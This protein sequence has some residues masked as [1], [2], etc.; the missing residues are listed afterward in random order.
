MDLP[1]GER[2]DGLEVWGAWSELLYVEWISQEVSTVEH[3]N[4]IQYH[5]INHTR[6]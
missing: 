1:K 6:G 5:M 2:G 3:R 4:Y